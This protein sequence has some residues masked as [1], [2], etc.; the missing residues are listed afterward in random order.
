MFHEIHEFTSMNYGIS[1]LFGGNAPLFD[2]VSEILGIRYFLNLPSI[3]DLV[4][5]VNFFSF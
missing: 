3:Q 1:K 5:P 2:Y 4:N